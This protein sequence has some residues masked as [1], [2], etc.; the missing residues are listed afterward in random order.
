MI[1][2]RAKQ[3]GRNDPCPCGS[4]KKFKKCHLGSEPHATSSAQVDPSYRQQR[5]EAAR[6]QRERQ[7]GLGKA[8]VSANFKGERFVAVKNRLF[9]SERFKTFHDFLVRY[10][11]TAL[12]PVWGTTE[13]RK[14]EPEA[15]PLRCGTRHSVVTRAS[16]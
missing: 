4:G 16:T 6:I 12:G 1:R 5:L 8:I 7:Q 2:E 3:P 10:A 11:M 13:L 14:P 9:Y 15:T